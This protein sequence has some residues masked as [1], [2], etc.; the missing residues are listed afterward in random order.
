MHMIYFVGDHFIYALDIL[1]LLPSHIFN[2]AMCK[3]F[4]NRA[5]TNKNEVSPKT[6]FYSASFPVTN[7]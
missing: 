4:S 6:P 3:G 7:Q 5:S 1:L 2:R